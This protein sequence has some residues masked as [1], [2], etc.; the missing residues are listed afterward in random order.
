M[1][2]I[3]KRHKIIVL[4]FKCLQLKNLLVLHKNK[5]I[6]PFWQEQKEIPSQEG[7]RIMGTVDPHK[8]YKSTVVVL[9]DLDGNLHSVSK[10]CM[11]VLRIDLEYIKKKKLKAGD[12]WPEVWGFLHP[13]EERG[14]FKKEFRSK[15]K[16]PKDNEHAFQLIPDQHEE[17]DLIVKV[18]PLYTRRFAKTLAY[19]LLIEEDTEQIVISKDMSKPRL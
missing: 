17:I 18:A 2:L 16:L 7:L 9:V 11:S 10:E 19:L 3:L 5:Y 15:Y 13:F 4:E 8:T 6:I 12:I 1:I 14:S